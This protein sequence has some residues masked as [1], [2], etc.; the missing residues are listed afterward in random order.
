MVLRVS[1]GGFRFARE[2]RAFP[3]LSPFH[4]DHF[5]APKETVLVDLAS[6]G[7]SQNQ[8]HS[9]ALAVLPAK[10]NR[11]LRGAWLCT[12]D[13]R[14]PVVKLAIHNNLLNR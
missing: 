7:F 4:Q 13:A 6:A 5:E 2:R 1:Q 9:K 10:R 11:F 14:A 3:V 12:R 8:L